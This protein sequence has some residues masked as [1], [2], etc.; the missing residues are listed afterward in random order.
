MRYNAAYSPMRITTPI[1]THAKLP[2]DSYAH[3][4]LEVHV[5]SKLSGYYVRQLR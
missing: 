4:M 3:D 5:A 1:T 2:G